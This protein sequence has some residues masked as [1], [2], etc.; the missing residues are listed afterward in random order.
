MM[1]VLN[2]NGLLNPKIGGGTAERTIQ[3][4]KYLADYHV[5]CSILTID[6]DITNEII[7]YLYKVKLFALPYLTK[8]FYIP[9]FNPIKISSIVKGADIVHLMGN[10]TLLNA[11]VYIFIKWHSKPY[12]IC[13]AGGL[14]IIGRSQNLKFLYNYIIGNRLINHASKIIAITSDEKKYYL[15]RNIDSRS[16][17]LIPNGIQVGDSFKDYES[18]FRQQFELVG[19]KYILYVGRLNYIKGI[20]LLINCFCQVAEE[21]SEY[22]LVIAGTDEGMLGSLQK[23]VKT[24]KLV[25]RVKFIGF[26]DGIYK[27]QAYRSA[28]LVVIPSRQEA[29]SIVILEAGLFRCP[30]LF[31]DQ[32]GLTKFSINEAG[33]EVPASEDGL[34]NGLLSFYKYEQ[35][36]IQYGDNLYDIVLEQYNWSKIID[37]YLSLYKNILNE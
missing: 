30:V 31:T 2:V 34:K 15:S 9:I 26:I 4:S 19:K 5:D 7:S 1:N 29:M 27:D 13:P 22:T 37:S 28:K 18:E 8:R 16:I 36:F 35:R 6:A 33:L 10:W 3:M 21:F 17:T 12:V 25:S 24:H 20:D 11:I 32:C 23:T 14:K